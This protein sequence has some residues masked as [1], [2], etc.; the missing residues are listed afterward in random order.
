MPDLAPFTSP[1][2]MVTLGEHYAGDVATGHVDRDDEGL[3]LLTEKLDSGDPVIIDIT[4]W[5]SDPHSGAHFVVVTGLSW[6]ASNTNATVRYN[7]P[8]TGR[9]EWAD[10]AGHEGVWQAWQNNGDPGGSGWWLAIPSSAPAWL[11]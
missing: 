9:T 8:L 3:E 2:G 4:T 7:N 1:S 5:L 11:P 6:D 10:W